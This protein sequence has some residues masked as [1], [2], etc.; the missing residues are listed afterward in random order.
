MGL[1]HQANI[2]AAG[3]SFTTLKRR[4]LYSA[5]FL[6]GYPDALKKSALGAPAGT[7]SAL[8]QEGDLSKLSSVYNESSSIKTQQAFLDYVSG[9]YSRSPRRSPRRYY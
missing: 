5:H 7:T 6:P 8:F 9:K 2:D 3:M 1:A 4:D